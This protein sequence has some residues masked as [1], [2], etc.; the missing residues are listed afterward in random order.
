MSEVIKGD[1]PLKKPTEVDDTNE[2]EL[3]YKYATDIKL[4]MPQSTK[5]V[6]QV[7]AY[8]NEGALSLETAFSYLIDIAGAADQVNEILNLP[9]ETMNQ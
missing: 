6:E 2:T 5:I 7:K 3:L 4:M 8:F 1:F 9:Q